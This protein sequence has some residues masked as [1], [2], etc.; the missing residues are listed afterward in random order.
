M[1]FEEEDK[2]DLLK[3]KL[4]KIDPLRLTPL[5][6]LNILYELKEFGNKK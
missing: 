6:A 4:D 1:A 2:K 5:E 3:E